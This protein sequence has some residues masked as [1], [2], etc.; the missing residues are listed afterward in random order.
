MY[1]YIIKRDALQANAEYAKQAEA[2]FSQLQAT[3]VKPLEDLQVQLN[4]QKAAAHNAHRGLLAAQAKATEEEANAAKLRE[5]GE[6]AQTDHL[7]ELEEAQERHHG[8]TEAL[9]QQSQRVQV[10]KS[11]CRFNTLMLNDAFSVTTIASFSRSRQ[12]ARDWSLS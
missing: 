11:A 9:K 4:S 7:R 5:Q 2:A 8:H 6:Q 1:V 10:R 12:N 3:L